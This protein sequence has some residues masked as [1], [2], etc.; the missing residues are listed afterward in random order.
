[1]ASGPVVVGHYEL[2]L[3]RVRVCLAATV[4]DC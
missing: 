4:C 3:A 2:V 1:M